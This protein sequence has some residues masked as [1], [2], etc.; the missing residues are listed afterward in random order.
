MFILDERSLINY[1]SLYLNMLEK[2][3]LS[4]AQSK[5]IKKMLNTT[6]ENILRMGKKREKQ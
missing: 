3:N 5:T 6:V 2:R 1:L 4:Q